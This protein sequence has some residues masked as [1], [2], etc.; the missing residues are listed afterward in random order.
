M[1]RLGTFLVSA[2]CSHARICTTSYESVAG[3][4]Q[5]GTLGCILPCQIVLLEGICLQIEEQLEAV[6]NES[7]LP[8]FGDKTAPVGHAQPPPRRTNHLEQD[9]CGRAEL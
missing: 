9:L 5:P 3:G 8:P 4:P 1:T 6:F 7:I 2:I